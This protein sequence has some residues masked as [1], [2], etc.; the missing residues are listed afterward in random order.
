MKMWNKLLLGGAAAMLLAGVANAQS[1]PIATID[2]A[3]QTAD[4]DIGADQ[5]EVALST[6]AL[7][8]Q[9][10]GDVVFT[11]TPSTAGSD[12][13]LSASTDA[14][15]TVS[16]DNLVFSQA[17]TGAEVSGDGTAC[18]PQ[19]T[20]QSGGGFNGTEVVYLVQN[21]DTCDA[22]GGATEV[23]TL[24]IPTALVTLEDANFSVEIAGPGGISTILA[25]TTYDAD[26]GTD[27]I[28]P[29]VDVLDPYSLAVTTADFFDGAGRTAPADESAILALGQDP[30]FSAFVDPSDPTATVLTD[31]VGQHTLT[32]NSTFLDVERTTSADLG[33]ASGTITVTFEDASGFEDVTFGGTSMTQSSEDDTVFTLSSSDLS[34]LGADNIQVELDGETSVQPQTVLISVETTTEGGASIDLAETT[35]GVIERDGSTSETFSW[36]SLEN[37]PNSQNVFR[38]LDVTE[39]DRIIVEVDTL[40]TG[41]DNVSYDATTFLADRLS[42]GGEI[43]VSGAELGDQLTSTGNI[44]NTQDGVTRAT[45]QFFVEASGVEFERLL[46]GAN[47]GITTMGDALQGN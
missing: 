16:L 22:E 25:E 9:Q 10:Q 32:D 7:I 15:I 19:A 17:L 39:G 36:V 26:T 6:D 14:L 45:I 24:E 2:A 12:F 8:G 1:T 41:E 27:G 21:L 28:Q 47:G 35:L 43:V 5:G 46:F 3:G 29:L 38:L 13:D 33:S 44:D 31:T 34:T 23:L 4:D 40:N 11:I 18:D 37:T 42:D 30:A 20:V